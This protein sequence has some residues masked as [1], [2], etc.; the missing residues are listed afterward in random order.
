MRRSRVA[1][2]E[3]FVCCSDTISTLCRRFRGFACRTR[4][5]GLTPS[6]TIL[7]A[8]ARLTAIRRANLDR[9]GCND[10][11]QFA[12]LTG[13]LW[14]YRGRYGIK[15]G[16]VVRIACRPES[17]QKPAVRLAGSIHQKAKGMIREPRLMGNNGSRAG[18]ADSP[19]T[20]VLRVKWAAATAKKVTSPDATYIRSFFQG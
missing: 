18:L 20:H 17:R 3:P 4:H 2:I 8:A 1:A 16:T 6:A 11:F 14:K 9:R 5:R 13:Q 10:V 15:C 7:R 19:Q 12:K